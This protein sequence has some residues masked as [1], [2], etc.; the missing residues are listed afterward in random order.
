MAWG[1][2]FASSG[3]SCSDDLNQALIVSAKNNEASA[4]EDAPSD[5]DD[6]QAKPVR[7]SAAPSTEEVS[8][9]ICDVTG[10]YSGAQIGPNF[11]SNKFKKNAVAK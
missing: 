9:T 7:G 10:F 8:G 6:A 5:D 11:I 4:Q 3:A 1:L 2:L